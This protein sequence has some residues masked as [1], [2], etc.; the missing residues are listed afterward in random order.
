MSDPLRELT[1]FVRAGETGSFSRVA[2]QLGGVAALR[3]RSSGDAR[4]GSARCTEVLDAERTHG[5]GPCQTGS[6]ADLYRHYG[7]DC[8]RD[9]ADAR[10]PPSQAA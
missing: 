8:Q 7:I 3:L 2:R 9:R 10:F 6:I 1:A 5:H 4:L